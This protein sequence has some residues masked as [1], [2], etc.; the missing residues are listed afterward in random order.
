MW[1]TFASS[2]L[3]RQ[4]SGCPCTSLVLQSDRALLHVCVMSRQC[5]VLFLCRNSARALQSRHAKSITH[6]GTFA[7]ELYVYIIRAVSPQLIYCICW[8]WYTLYIYVNLDTIPAHMTACVRSPNLDRHTQRHRNTRAGE[9]SP[10]LHCSCETGVSARQPSSWVSQ[11]CPKHMWARDGP[12]M[13]THA[14][15]SG[16]T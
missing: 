4:I 16:W 8:V 3:L 12:G 13:D 14:I 9:R 10:L 7:Y 11:A 15:S 5:H 6:Q 1:R 2:R